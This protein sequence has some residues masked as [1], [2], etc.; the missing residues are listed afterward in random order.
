ME[1]ID[2]P[3][4][5]TDYVA[6]EVTPEWLKSIRKPPRYINFIP[7]LCILCEGEKS[8]TELEQML[9]LRQPTVSQQLARLRAEDH[10]LQHDVQPARRSL[11]EHVH[12]SR[13]RRQYRR[14]D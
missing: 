4:L 3:R 13:L 1:N 2:K 5:R 10:R 12:P 9:E 11:A 8:V 7:E 6:Q 14:G